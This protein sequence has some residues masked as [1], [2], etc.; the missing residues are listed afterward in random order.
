[1][2]EPEICGFFCYEAGWYIVVIL[3]KTRRQPTRGKKTY[4]EEFQ[5]PSAQDLVT[6]CEGEGYDIGSPEKVQALCESAPKTPL[7]RLH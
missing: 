7:R 2:T 5:A 3:D 1:M 4:C 6:L